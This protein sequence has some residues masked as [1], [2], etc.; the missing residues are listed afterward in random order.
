MAT[1]PPTGPMGITKVIPSYLYYQYNDDPA[2]QAF[3][4]AQN[5]MSQYFLDWFQNINLP[6]YTGIFG[7][8]L[9]WVA[10]GLYNM[11]RPTLSVEQVNSIGAFG[12]FQFGGLQFG[13]D[14]VTISGQTIPVTDDVFQRVITWHRYKGDGYQYCTPWLKRRVHRFLNGPN[15]IS[16]Y[17]DSTYDVSVHYSGT[18][19][20]ITIPNNQIGQVFQYC[21]ADGVLALP[22]GY[23]YTVAL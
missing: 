11:Y 20:T 9:D 3:V 15:G 7:P 8:M 13:G 23:T 10:N 18:N 22:I 21:V 14:Q 1:F 16:P 5:V 4:D 17:I 19:V 2:C 12:T 6:I